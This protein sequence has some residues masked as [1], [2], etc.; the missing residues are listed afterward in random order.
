MPALLEPQWA[1]SEGSGQPTRTIIAPLESNSRDE[2]F[3]FADVTTVLSKRWQPRKAPY[4][5]IIARSSSSDRLSHSLLYDLDDCETAASALLW[6]G[7]KAFDS[8][9]LHVEMTLKSLYDLALLLVFFKSSHAVGGRQLRPRPLDR[10]PCIELSHLPFF[11]KPLTI[12]VTHG[13]I[14]YC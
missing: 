5:T 12:I 7:A 1:R 8:C 4:L 11:L 10:V 14:H 3:V 13:S 6:Y 2:F 9:Q